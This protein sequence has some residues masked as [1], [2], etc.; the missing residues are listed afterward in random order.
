MMLR[1]LTAFVALCIL[2]SAQTITVTEKVCPSA[3]TRVTTTTIVSTIHVLPTS[4]AASTKDTMSSEAFLSSTVTDISSDYPPFPTSMT[5]YGAESTKTAGPPVPTRCSIV[6]YNE[7]EDVDD[8]YCELVL[9]F[10]M[11]LFGQSNTTIFPS[12]NGVRLISVKE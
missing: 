10:N 3:T 5:G 12:S 2:A 1:S 11:T 8:G 7:Y 6:G 9:P 4:S